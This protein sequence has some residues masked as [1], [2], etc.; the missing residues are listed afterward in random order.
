MPKSVIEPSENVTEASEIIFEGTIVSVSDTNLAI[1]DLDSPPALR[2]ISLDS[3]SRWET[4][5]WNHRNDYS[6]EESDD[7]DFN[8]EGSEDE[9]SDDE[10]CE[11]KIPP[12]DDRKEWPTLQEADIKGGLEKQ[13]GR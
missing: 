8:E 5:Q 1:Q 3:I 12:L 2:L 13:G 7:E 9:S 4:R 11:D 10:D 6:E